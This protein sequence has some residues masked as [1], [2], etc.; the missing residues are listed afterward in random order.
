MIRVVVG[1]ERPDQLHVIRV[2]DV[3]DSP[4]VPR[5]IHDDALA[6]CAVAYKVDEV[7]HAGGDAV[8]LRKVAAGKQL[9]EVESFAHALEYNGR[10]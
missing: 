7:D 4:D 5:R 8:R 10:T 9:A 6:R 2:D 1:T 3:E